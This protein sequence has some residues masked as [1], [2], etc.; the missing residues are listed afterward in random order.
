[1]GAQGDD[2]T[3]THQHA[4][5]GDAVHK[6]S[7]QADAAT[8]PPVTVEPVVE[9]LAAAGM[10][11]LGPTI[12]TRQWTQEELLASAAD[13]AIR[14]FDLVGSA[15]GIRQTTPGTWQVLRAD[16][17]PGGAQWGSP[18]PTYEA[19]LESL[20]LG[21][22]EAGDTRPVLS[23][24]W[25]SDMAFE[26]VS[27]GDGRFIM[28]GA[29]TYRDCPLPLMLQ[30]ENDLGH[31]GAVLAGAITA[32]GM[33]GTTA[34]GT[35]FFDDSPAGRQF[36][37]VIAARGRF[38]VSIDVA[39]A[40][41]A[42][43][44][45]DEDMAG[46]MRFSRLKIMGLTGTPF[47]AFEDAYIEVPAQAQAASVTP[48]TD[49][50]VYVLGER[51]GCADCATEQVTQPTALVA[52]GGPA[53]APRSWFDNPQF[54]TPGSDPRLIRQPKSMGGGY[55]CPLTV[56]AD[57]RIYG[58]FG[59]NKTC[60]TA[61]PNACTRLPMSGTGYAK[62]HLRP[63][64]TAE[65]ADG[66]GDPVMVGHITMG[67]GHYL[68]DG[69]PRKL[70][71]VRAHYDG[72]PGVTIMAHVRAGDDQ[73]GGW[74]AGAVAEE[75]TDAQ[76]RKFTRMSVSG[77]WRKFPGTGLEMLACTAVVSPGFP[78]A[79]GA[80]AAAGIDVA[81]QGEGDRAQPAI[82]Y[83]HGEIAALAAA[84]IVV[85]P[86]PWERDIMALEDRLDR[87]EAENR[88]LRNVTA[89]LRTLSV[90][91]LLEHPELHARNG[92]SAGV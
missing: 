59:S 50:V 90:A 12:F 67:C 1:M 66:Q 89:P 23:T 61:Y 48:A 7:H 27:T 62:F 56:T 44:G 39:E 3:H 77:H 4:H 28:E 8:V 32:T 51:A 75:V 30:T 81:D 69:D 35:G 25:R 18:D 15:W 53:F 60:H 11:P 84:G 72:G 47:P 31:F 20:R 87:L 85:Q 6:H 2:A 43:P 5:D 92:E 10:Y 19:A 57:G 14:P 55:A 83:I 29:I 41:V 13:L 78:V 40:T 21:L 73:Y 46:D 88:S 42:E 58:H 82:T 68:D 45:P 79:A 91:R 70:D 49:G 22:A 34:V 76:I 16:G 33:V 38:G 64:T 86:M 9:P 63:Y 36:A 52:A 26:G 71:E 37:D 74:F 54:G 65:A 17:S 80:L 24:T